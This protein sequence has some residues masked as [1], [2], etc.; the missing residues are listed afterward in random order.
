M[1]LK[2]SGA[3]NKTNVEGIEDVAFKT[4]RPMQSSA[5][6]LK[7]GPQGAGGLAR[8]PLKQASTTQKQR[9]ARGQAD[10]QLALILSKMEEMASRQREQQQTLVVPSQSAQATISDALK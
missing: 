3:K 5:L 9:P 10:D 6:Q 7:K 8:I 2:E 4:L 1:E